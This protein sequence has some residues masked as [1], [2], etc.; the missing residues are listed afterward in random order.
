MPLLTT[1]SKLEPKL[2]PTSHLRSKIDL[3][4]SRKV[5]KLERKFRMKEKRLKT[6]KPLKS[7]NSSN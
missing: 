7:M 4:T 5:E 3:T 2:A 1:P 6:Y